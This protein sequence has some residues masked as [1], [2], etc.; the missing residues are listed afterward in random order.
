MENITTVGIDLAKRNCHF[1]GVNHTGRLVLKRKCSTERL[2]LE[3]ERLGQEFTIAFEACGSSHYWGREFQKRNYKV[4]LL[5]AQHVARYRLNQKNDYNDAQAICEASVRPNVYPVAVKDLGRQ[6][7]QHFLRV[8]ERLIGEEVRIA[9]QLHGLL[10]EY[11][12]RAPKGHLRLIRF[13]RELLVEEALTGPIREILREDESALETVRVR[14]HGMERAM[15]GIAQ[16]DSLLRRMMSIP[17]VGV[18]TALAAYCATPDPQQFKSGRSFA[19]FHGLVP[20]QYS[21]GGETR[22][23]SLPKNGSYPLRRLLIHGARSVLRYSKGRTDS[24]SLYAVRLDAK[25]QRNVAIV[26]IANKIARILWAIMASDDGQYRT[27]AEP[28]GGMSG[29]A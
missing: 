10:L 12:Y 16:R 1:V 8:R 13:V 29:D 19:A 6:E 18:I 20:V 26:A 17:G 21:T 7:V 2:L 24:L 5:P 9:N 3:V 28:R 11:G 4:K 14:L 22:L 27:I 23:G 25:K 15:K